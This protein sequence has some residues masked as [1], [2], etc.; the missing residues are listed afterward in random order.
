[1][2]TLLGAVGWMVL[3]V[4]LTMPAAADNSPSALFPE[5]N[6]DPLYDQFTYQALRDITI[7][8]SW[9]Q[10]EMR[11]VL[12]DLTLMV[13]TTHPAHASINFRFSSKATPIDRARLVTV[14]E[15]GVPIFNLL[16]ELAQQV[17][18]TIRVHQDLVLIIPE[19]APR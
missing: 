8:A 18:F 3:T 19:N 4:C 11:T 9:N 13:R 7:D 14:S 17:P 1:M 2:K 10:A 5:L 6:R 15:R 16:E 12:R